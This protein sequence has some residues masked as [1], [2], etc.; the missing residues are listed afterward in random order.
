MKQS[1][2]H[3]IGALSFIFPTY[4]EVLLELTG[5]KEVLKQHRKKSV[6][7]GGALSSLLSSPSRLATL[8]TAS[9]SA[10][11]SEMLLNSGLLELMVQ[12]IMDFCH[13]ACHSQGPGKDESSSVSEKN[14]S[15]K[16]NYVSINQLQ[17][18][19]RFLTCCCK[20]PAIKDWMGEG[21]YQFWFLLLCKLCGGPG[22]HTNS[23]F[24]TP[25]IASS[26]SRYASFAVETATV[27]LL[28]SC[29]HFHPKNQE[30]M[31]CLLVETIG[32]HPSSNASDLSSKSK[33][34]SHVSGFIRQ[35]ILQMLLEEETIPICLHIEDD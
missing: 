20:E 32:G 33:V 11:T 6:D 2:D 10:V 31:A 1:I 5:T 3:L 4:Y 19:L 35:L 29:V 30:K 22:V 13:S 23:L 7:A 26:I 15:Q 17:H 25:G 18:L 34:T 16:R 8:A 14:L 28:C 27:E 24:S 12:G 9:Q 21:G